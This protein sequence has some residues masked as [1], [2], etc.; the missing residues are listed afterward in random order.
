[1]NIDSLEEIAHN[2]L[3][4]KRVHRFPPEISGRVLHADADVFRT[5]LS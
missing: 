4:E 1:M 3:D 2:A 5:S